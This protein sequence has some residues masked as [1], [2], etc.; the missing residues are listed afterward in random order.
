MWAKLHREWLEEH[1]ELPFGIPS[2][3]T[4]KRV[5]QRLEP[6]A[7]QSCFAAWLESLV[8]PSGPKFMAIDGKTLRR[9]E[10]GLPDGSPFWRGGLVCASPGQESCFSASG[11][12]Q[13]GLLGRI[14][15]RT[16]NARKRVGYSHLGSPMPSRREFP[17]ARAGVEP[18]ESRRFELRRFSSLRTV[19]CHVDKRPRRDLNP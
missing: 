2:R 5:L 1:L 6:R 12:D 7:F 3:D 9:L 19:P 16:C 8:G 18:A 17:V 13:S 11:S 4:F 14:G 10:H 15:A